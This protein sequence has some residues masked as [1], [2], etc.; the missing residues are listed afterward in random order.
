MILLS[1]SASTQKNSLCLSTEA[2][3]LCYLKW[4]KKAQSGEDLTLHIKKALHK[5]KLEAKD[6][7]RIAVDVGPGSFTGCRIVVNAA[8]ALAF[9]NATPVVA[10]D[11]MTIM[12]RPF[13]EKKKKILTCLDAHRGLFYYQ[14]FDGLLNAQFE[15]PQVLAQEEFEKLKSKD[16]LI[17]GPENHLPDAK[18][19]S[20]LAWESPKSKTPWEN[21]E[22]LYIRAPDVVEA[23]SKRMGLE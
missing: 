12:A 16:H 22:P 9:V 11:S 13:K 19:L 1:L 4:S 10:F 2:K 14:I 20:Q 15:R 23:Y 8:K 21:L 5:A 3:V 6:V 18:A 7:K 17:L